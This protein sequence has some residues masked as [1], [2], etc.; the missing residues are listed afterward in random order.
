[1]KGSWSGG[2]NEVL[3]ENQSIENVIACSWKD[4]P[5]IQGISERFPG[6]DQAE[7]MASPICLMQTV[8]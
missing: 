3:Y 8:T 2:E 6:H 7:V 1:M 4:T 5:L